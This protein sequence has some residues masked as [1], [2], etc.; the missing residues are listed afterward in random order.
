MDMGKGNRK[1]LAGWMVAAAL[2]GVIL[3][4]GFQNNAEKFAVVDLRKVIMDS[5]INRE[6]TDKVN[7]GYSAR[8]AVLTFIQ[9]HRVVTEE[10]ALRLEQLELKPDKTDAEKLELE[11]VK[12]AIKDA[13]AEKVQLDAVTTPTEAQRQRLMTLQRI[14]DNASAILNQLQAKFN[15]DFENL[16]VKEQQDAVERAAKAATTVAKAKGYT[17]VY[18]SASVVYAANDITA[19]ATKEADK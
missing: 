6:T 15:D 12:K 1:G 10:Q 4:S 11:A 9:T 13:D 17:L 16:K 3:G 5:K 7:A 8:M 19:D 2:V 14:I 18:S